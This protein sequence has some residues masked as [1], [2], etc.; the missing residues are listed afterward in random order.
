MH[1][2]INITFVLLAAI[3][4]KGKLYATNT[5]L[6]KGNVLILLL[7]RYYIRFTKNKIFFDG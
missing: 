5:F 2:P 4:L 1:G 6:S 3:Q 7:I